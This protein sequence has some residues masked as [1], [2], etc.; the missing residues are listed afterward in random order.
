MGSEEASELIIIWKIKLLGLEKGK[1]YFI[2]LLS[3]ILLIAVAQK[4]YLL[5][6]RNKMIVNQ[7]VQLTFSSHETVQHTVSRY[8]MW[9]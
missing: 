8:S 3:P 7:I 9:K 4:P 5:P 6:K 1:N 2:S